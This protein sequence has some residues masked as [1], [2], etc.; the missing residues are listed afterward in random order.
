ML[1]AMTEHYDIGKLP[2]TDSV[3]VISAH[4][5]TLCAILRVFGRGIEHLPSEPDWKKMSAEHPHTPF[6]S[7][8]CAL[9]M[10]SAPVRYLN[11]A[12]LLPGTLTALTG[13]RVDYFVTR[14]AVERIVYSINKQVP[15][16]WEWLFGILEL[17]CEY[18]CVLDYRHD[19]EYKMLPQ[20]CYT[21]PE[22][23]TILI[24]DG[25]AKPSSASA[26]TQP[27]VTTSPQDSL[28]SI[29]YVDIDYYLQNVP[30]LCPLEPSRSIVHATLLG[31][32][33]KRIY[34]AKMLIAKHRAMLSVIMG[35]ETIPVCLR[36]HYQVQSS[37]YPLP[38]HIRNW[39]GFTEYMHECFPNDG[40]VI[41]RVMI[42]Q[43][44]QFQELLDEREEEQRKGE[45]KKETS[46]E[47]SEETSTKVDEEASAKPTSEVEPTSSK[48]AEPL[49]ELLQSESTDNPSRLPA[50]Y[51]LTSR[52]AQTPSRLPLSASDGAVPKLPV[53][54]R[55][56]QSRISQMPQ[57]LNTGLTRPQTA[58]YTLAEAST[59]APRTRSQTAAYP[60]AEAFEEM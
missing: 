46:V 38:G 59:S 54:Y 22:S 39:I 13:F 49:S 35:A 7:P 1:Q 41:T 58:A 29:P 52:R 30:L 18:V 14:A 34:E 3:G 20:N 17:G 21:S 26:S 12:R 2:Q 60:P 50:R 37:H 47:V 15:E 45:K 9:E 10:E 40:N 19:P 51:R 5:Y 44:I 53:R 32:K 24:R 28:S 8:R 6:S 31:T 23:E 43:A 11:T 16:P 55:L 56:T 36:D 4:P 48:E 33:R 57:R 42:L 27:S 25:L